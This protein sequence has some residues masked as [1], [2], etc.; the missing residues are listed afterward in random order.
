MLLDARADLAILAAP[1][2]FAIKLAIESVS[3]TGRLV[4]ISKRLIGR[5]VNDSTNTLPPN[6]NYAFS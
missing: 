3:G 6:S 1:A 5:H 4:E 2:D